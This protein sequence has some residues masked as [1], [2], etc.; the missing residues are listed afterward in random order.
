MSL[1]TLRLS[2]GIDTPLDFAAPLND[3]LTLIRIVSSTDP[4]VIQDDIVQDSSSM[5]KTF[6]KCSIQMHSISYLHDTDSQVAWIL[7]K[8]AFHNEMVQKLISFLQRGSFFLVAY[9][10]RMYY[11]AWDV[12]D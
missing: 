11:M 6:L 9:T 4:I 1:D 7:A 12:V 8:Q 2:I 5:L 3:L 10:L